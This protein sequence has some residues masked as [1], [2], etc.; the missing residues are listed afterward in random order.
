MKRSKLSRRRSKKIFRKGAKKVKSVNI[1]PTPMRG[2]FR[3]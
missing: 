3:L 2:G 1:A